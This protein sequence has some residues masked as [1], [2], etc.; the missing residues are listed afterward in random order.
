MKPDKSI[1]PNSLTSLNLLAGILGIVCALDGAPD[2]AFFL[3]L[4]AAGFD[5]FD[6]LERVHRDFLGHAF[7]VFAVAF[8]GDD[9]HVELVADFVAD[10][11]LLEPDHDHVGALDVLERFAASGGIDNGSFVGGEGVVHLDYGL[12]GDFHDFSLYR[13]I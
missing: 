7:V 6:A 2:R 3:M 10:H 13:G 9:L 11:R 5:F 1:F 12:V 4:A 8:G